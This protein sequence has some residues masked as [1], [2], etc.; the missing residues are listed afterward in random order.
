MAN[1]LRDVFSD[2]SP[3]YNLKITFDSYERSKDFYRALQHV[4]KTG[5]PAEIPGDVKMSTALTDGRNSYSLEEKLP[6]SQLM[7]FPSKDTFEREVKIYTGDYVKLKLERYNIE[8]G[9]VIQLKENPLLSMQVRL[10]KDSRR[11]NYTYSFHSEKAETIEEIANAYKTMIGFMDI[12][13]LFDGHDYRNNEELDKINAQYKFFKRMLKIYAHLTQLNQRLSLGITPQ[14]VNQEEQI[15][16]FFDI[17]ELYA[18]LYEHRVFRINAKIDDSETIG[19]INPDL[20]GKLEIGR[21]MDIRMKGQVQYNICGATVELYTVEWLANVVLKEIINNEDGTSLIKYG[22]NDLKPMFMS[23][24]AFLSEEEAQTELEHAQER[25][26]EYLN[27]LT[28]D[29]YMASLEG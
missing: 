21:Y 19:R 15:H 23:Y 7:V 3:Q 20:E 12:M 8:E 22:N 29:E 1:K 28:I 10:H 25:R 11:I 13:F 16:D 14:M 9:P 6:V 27:A 5:E 4:W 2:Q 26:E 18:V 17:E 24:S